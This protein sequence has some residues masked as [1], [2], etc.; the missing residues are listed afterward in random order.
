MTHEEF[1]TLVGNVERGIGRDPAALRKRLFRLACLGY[2]SLLAPLGLVLAVGLLFILPGIF[3]GA[4]AVG[5]L[6]LG[7]LILAGGFWAV[8]RALWVRLTPPEGCPLTRSQAPALFDM[9]D[10]L[11]SRLRSIPFDASWSS[12]ISTP[13]WCQ[14]RDWEFW[15]GAKTISSSVCR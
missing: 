15:A 11:R 14:C 9:L 6:I 8:G 12:R 2:L 5:L 10:E 1:D 4:G 3:G 7:A 13:P